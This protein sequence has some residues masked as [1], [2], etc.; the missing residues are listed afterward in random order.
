MS[1]LANVTVNGG[2][3]IKTGT[4]TS[5]IAGTRG[6]DAANEMV[7]HVF[8]G[9]LIVSVPLSISGAAPR[10][11]KPGAGTLSLFVS[12]ASPAWMAKGVPY[13]DREK[14]KEEI[15]KLLGPEKEKT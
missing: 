2:G 11:T 3:I 15:K 10:L 13:L 4:P 14:D 5:T 8:Q 1:T 6:L 12:G 7:F 9:T